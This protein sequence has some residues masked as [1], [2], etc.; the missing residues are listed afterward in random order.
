MIKVILFDCDGVIIKKHRRFSEILRKEFDIADDKMS[1]FFQGVFLDCEKGRADLKAELPK[2]LKSWQWPE[3]SEEFM[4]IW[5]E[6]EQEIDRE[7]K[8]YIISLRQK[9]IK[10]YLSTNNEK[11]RTE[12]L[13]NN[14]GLNSFLDGVFSSCYLGYLKPQIEF[15]EEVYKS[16]PAIQ[17][18]DVLMWDDNPS[19]VESASQ[20][21]FHSELYANLE[22]FRKIM[23]ERY[24]IQI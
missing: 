23:T 15:W 13:A 2:V 1:E 17:K 22:A 19:A 16:L 20:F 9:G 24:K 8:S 18:S 10:C 5:F 3:A 4:R 11:Y 7:M 14:A 6:S 21:G 12:Y